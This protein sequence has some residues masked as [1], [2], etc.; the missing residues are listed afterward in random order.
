MEFYCRAITLVAKLASILCHKETFSL[1]ET[2]CAWR[3]LMI[4][5]RV[6]LQCQWPIPGPFNTEAVS[7]FV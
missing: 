4:S 7:L 5:V 6:Q 1:G 3:E 2:W